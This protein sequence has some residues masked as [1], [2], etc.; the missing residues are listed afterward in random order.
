MN[1]KTLTEAHKNRYIKAQQKV[2]ELLG[3]SDRSFL[4]YK[5]Q[6]EKELK[7]YKKLRPVAS[8]SFIQQIQSA[9]LIMVGDFHSEA[10]SVRSLLRICRSLDSNSIVLGLECLSVEMQKYIDAYLMGDLSENKFLHHIKWSERWGFPFK[11]YRPLFRWAIDNKVSVYGVNY[12]SPSLKLRD[13]KMARLIHQLQKKNPHKRFVLQIGDYHLASKHLP[14]QIKKVNPRLRQQVVFQSPDEVYFNWIR[15]N[16][17]KDHV[18]FLKLGKNKWCVFSVLPWIKWENYLINLEQSIENSSYDLEDPSESLDLMDYLNQHI[19]FLTEVFKIPVNLSEYEVVQTKDALRK[20]VKKLSLPMAK[21]HTE[22]MALDQVVF[23]PE[24][25]LGFVSGNTANHLGQ[26]AAYLFLHQKGLLKKTLHMGKDHFLQNI[27][28]EMLVYFLTKL[29]NPKRKTATLFDVRSF[30]KD[31]YF[32]EHGKEVLNIA[33]E[34]KLNEMRFLEKA[35]KSLIKNS[36][37]YRKHRSHKNMFLASQILGRM[38]GEKVYFA[39]SKKMISGSDLERFLF[40]VELNS[41]HF[42]I[43]YYESI[44]IIDSWPISFKSKFDRF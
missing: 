33:L 32:A 29:S 1:H 4:N 28:V 11:L 35:Q 14:L 17:H 19:E 26:M 6:Y 7:S 5:K 15:R 22:K 12:S 16:K 8:E 24:L 44:E 21:A 3:D 2:A 9:D 43:K 38:L 37:L 18:D 10:Q 36:T 39:L 41:V 27:W 34:Q 20:K 30:L 31:E 13:Q 40:Q 42:P 25:K 23:V